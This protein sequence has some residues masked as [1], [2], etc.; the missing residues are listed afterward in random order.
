MD[1]DTVYL[2]VPGIVMGFVECSKTSTPLPSFLSADSFVHHSQWGADRTASIL[3]NARC[4]YY[5]DGGYFFVA[6]EE[7][8][9]HI[10]NLFRLQTG[11][12][13]QH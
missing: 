4:K 5:R 6:K 1:I 9:K 11:N 2:E 3:D 7:I 12:K 13:P 8:I 10:G